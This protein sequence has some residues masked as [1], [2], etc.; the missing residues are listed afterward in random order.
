[1]SKY[2]RLMRASS[3]RMT[4]KPELTVDDLWAVRRSNLG[5]GFQAKGIRHTFGTCGPIADG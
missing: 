2:H 5:V 1:M 4:S 3:G